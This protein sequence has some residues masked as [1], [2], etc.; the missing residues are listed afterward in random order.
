MA[1]GTTKPIKDVKVGDKVVATDP[2]TGKRVVRTVLAV[3]I[4][5]DTAL[6]D[7]TV[8]VNGHNA[9]IHTTQHHPVWDASKKMWVDAGDLAAGD[10]LRTAEKT[11]N[12]VIDI[13]NFDGARSMYDLT[14][15][16]THTYYVL[17]GSTPV[18]VHN[19]G[20]VAR[21]ALNDA[22]YDQAKA[23]ADELGG[24][25]EGQSIA[26]DPGI[27]GAFDGIPASLKEILPGSANNTRALANTVGRAAGSAGKAGYSGVW[28][29]I[30]AHGLSAAE[31]LGSNKI[32]QAMSEGVISRISVHTADGWAHFF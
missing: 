28:L 23:V 22:E 9:V 20:T 14:V 18:L 6:T 3:H 1:N 30:R 5:H 12:N 19:C 8:K 17:A 16:T 4:N 24:H 25:F 32:P 26:N 7:L 2:Q 21:N 31:A 29:F 11:T 10:E 15:D 27:D 13:A